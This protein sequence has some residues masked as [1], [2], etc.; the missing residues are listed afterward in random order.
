MV[1]NKPTNK[2]DLPVKRASK[3]QGWEKRIITECGV[4]QIT[5]V[6][7]PTEI[8]GFFGSGKKAAV[9][10]FVDFAVG[11]DGKAIFFDAKVTQDSVWNL[12]KYVFNEKSI[13]QYHSLIGARNNSNLAGYMILF[14]LHKRISWVPIDVIERCYNNG[15]ASI[16]YE[17]EGVKTVLECDPMPLREMWG[18]K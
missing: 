2:R 14:W 18:L 5:C 17:T 7:I 12:R 11:C 3:W 13:H 8:R 4:Q 10:S 6:K 16:T 1:P 9:R 15:I